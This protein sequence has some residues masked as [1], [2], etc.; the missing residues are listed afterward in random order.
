M[1]LIG[2]NGR[3]Q[4]LE[5]KAPKEQPLLFFS[6]EHVPPAVLSEFEAFYES[7]SVDEEAERPYRD[8]SDDEVEQLD[9]WVERLAR[10][11]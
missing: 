9:R 11:G 1:S 8:L 2:M 7:L 3:M 6:F 4:R 10:Y 5:E